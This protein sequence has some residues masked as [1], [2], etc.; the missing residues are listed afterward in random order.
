MCEEAGYLGAFLIS[1]LS[2]TSN[3]LDIQHLLFFGPLQIS[4]ELLR[5]AT[6]S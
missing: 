3:P 4:V 5:E 2:C 6:G 1:I